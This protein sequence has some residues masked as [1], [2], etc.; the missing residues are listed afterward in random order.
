ME[1]RGGGGGGGGRGGAFSEILVAERQSDGRL[2]VSSPSV[3]RSDWY[4]ALVDNFRL[5]YD[6]RRG[7]VATA[8]CELEADSA[9][10]GVQTVNLRVESGN[11]GAQQFYK[12]I[13]FAEDPSHMSWRK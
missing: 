2:V 13:G 6:S 9:A 7:K 12:R 8:L 11:A 5:R 3:Q 10:A 1:E 4:D